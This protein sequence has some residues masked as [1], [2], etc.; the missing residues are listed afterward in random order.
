MKPPRA[1]AALL[2]LFL[3]AS[4][5]APATVTA[6]GP[7]AAVLT[8]GSCTTVPSTDSESSDVTLSINW[9]GPDPLFVNTPFVRTIDSWS[10]GF[11]PTIEEQRRNAATRTTTVPAYGG[12]VYAVN[13]HFYMTPESHDLG[14]PDAEYRLDCTAA[15]AP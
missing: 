3:C 10:A 9:R 12:T 14:L 4:A 6:R 11:A 2:A 13:I 1:A 7:K 8:A 5:L 15:T